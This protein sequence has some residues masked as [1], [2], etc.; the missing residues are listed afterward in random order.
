MSVAHPWLLENGDYPNQDVF[1]R[2]TSRSQRYSPATGVMGR[3]AIAVTDRSLRK[4][5]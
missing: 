2:V 5:G 3:S 4:S 1:I